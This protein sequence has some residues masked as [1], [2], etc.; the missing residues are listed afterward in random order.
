M[1]SGSGLVSTCRP[2][3]QLLPQ[4]PELDCV[5]GPFAPIVGE[6][7]EHKHPERLVFLAKGRELRLKLQDRLQTPLRECLRFAKIDAGPVEYRLKD[8]QLQPL[9]AALVA[10]G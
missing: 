7:P 1:S 8:R 10:V 4:R 5:V 6:V 3:A 9:H 2:L